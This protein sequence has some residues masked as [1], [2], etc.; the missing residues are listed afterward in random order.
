MLNVVIQRKYEYAGVIKNDSKKAEGSTV[1][2]LRVY[3]E[4]GEK[5][6]YFRE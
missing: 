4:K 5:L 1:G 3:D 6:F 2:E